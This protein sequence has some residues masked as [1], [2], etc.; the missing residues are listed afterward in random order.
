MATVKR[1][2]GRGDVRARSVTP[3]SALSV[4]VTGHLVTVEVEWLSSVTV[5]VVGQQPHNR[6]ARRCWRVR[7]GKTKEDILSDALCVTLCLAITG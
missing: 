5:T 3:V 6:V 4:A 1:H 7:L 2:V